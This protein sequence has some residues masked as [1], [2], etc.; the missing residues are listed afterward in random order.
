METIRFR[1]RVGLTLCAGLG[2]PT[3]AAT[4]HPIVVIAHGWGSN[5][6]SARNQ[7]I[8]DALTAAGIGAFLLDF[9]GHGESEG[10]ADHVTLADLADDLRDAI[11]LLERRADVGA[12]GLAGSSSGAAVALAV[13]ATDARVRALVLRAPSVATRQAD[14][15]RVTAPTL[16][17]QGEEDPLAE[18]A[19][20]LAERFVCEHRV[21]VVPQA[22]HL[23]DEP[24]TL[25]I[26]VRET[27]RWFRRWLAGERQ[28]AGGQ[29][30]LDPPV[31][32]AAAVPHFT[33]RTD[34]GTALA[35]RL[36]AHRGPQTVVVALPRGGVVVGEQ[37]A[38]H[39]GA[40]LDVLVSRKIRAPMQPELAIGAVAEGGVVV[41]NDA[42][43]VDLALGEAVRKCQLAHAQQ[44]L[45]EH[46]ATYR[47]VLPHAPLRGRTVIVT[48][49]GVATGATLEAAIA[50]I[51]AAEA[52]RIVVA[53]PGGPQD[54]LEE[55]RDLTGVSE[56]VVVA[57]PKLFW[58]VGQL[59]DT[60]EPVS[61]EEV[62]VI[63][64]A[65]RRRRASAA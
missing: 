19:R 18:R 26:A 7:A 49:D 40:D 6:A 62:C 42:V 31:A 23:F 45:E 41:W 52:A 2:R 21:C 27:V 15:A 1:N 61:T 55:I 24:G 43:I 51:R 17:V 60:F 53:L 54:T 65:A 14:A 33:D 5:K 10:T 46:A 64:R 38:R 30:D 58:A 29:R 56:V 13:A 9:S 4:P 44:E 3:G 34:A 35:K 12:I 37:I 48:D 36:T 22:G 16:L 63:L 8:A 32:D 57:V 28:N 47:A 59:Y 50:A 39:L 25:E 11:D 20:R